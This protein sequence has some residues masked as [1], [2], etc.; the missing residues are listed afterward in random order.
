MA[1]SPRLTRRLLR[2]MESA[3]LAMG[4]GMEGEG[5]WPADLPR[6]DLDDAADWISA[7]LARRRK[8]NEQD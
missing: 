6:D 2:A 5:D 1:A 3:V 7:Q 4:A 8:P